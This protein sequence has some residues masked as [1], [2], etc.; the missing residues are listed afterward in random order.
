MPGG[1]ADGGSARQRPALR[2][3]RRGVGDGVAL[4]ARPGGAA[5]ATRTSAGLVPDEHP[6]P[7]QLV[8]GRAALRRA[9]HPRAAGSAN[10]VTNSWHE[11]RW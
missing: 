9:D 1:L 2:A 6:A 3:E 7:P 4:K 8:A 11:H 10:K 5:A